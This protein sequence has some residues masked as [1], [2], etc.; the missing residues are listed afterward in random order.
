LHES[1]SESGREATLALLRSAD[2][3]PEAI[4]AFNDEVAIGAMAAARE[5]GLSVPDDIAVAGFDD[6]YIAQLSWPPLTTIH[7]PIADLA[8]QAVSVVAAGGGFDASQIL[9][10][11]RLVI[12]GTT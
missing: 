4:F 3:Q 10:P 2:P 9:L 1:I 12:R 11:T 5:L 7:Q 6:S 8:F